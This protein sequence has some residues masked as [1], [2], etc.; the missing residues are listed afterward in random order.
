[1]LNSEIRKI[2]IVSEIGLK[3]RRAGNESYDIVNSG[4]TEL[5]VDIY[6]NEVLTGNII[7]D[8]DESKEVSGTK[9]IG[10]QEGGENGQ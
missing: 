1:M 6:N 10:K 3:L 2:T 7:L 8:A 5:N 9:F 4:N